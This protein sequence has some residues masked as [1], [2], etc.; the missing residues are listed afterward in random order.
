MVNGT[1]LSCSS[2]GMV[3]RDTTLASAVRIAASAYA[4]VALAAGTKRARS[5]A[6]IAAA[7]GEVVPSASTI[8][9]LLPDNGYSASPK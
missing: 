5:T 1:S 6:R 7:T 4:R 3:E 2:F 9:S 8:A